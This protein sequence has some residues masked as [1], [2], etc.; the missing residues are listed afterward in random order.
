MSTSIVDALRCCTRGLGARAALGSARGMAVP[1]ALDR[2]LCGDLPCVGWTRPC[3]H[4]MTAQTSRTLTYLAPTFPFIAA[5]S[6]TIANEE[7]IVELYS[8]LRSCRVGIL[9]IDAVEG[10]AVLTSHLLKDIHLSR[11]EAVRIAQAV[12]RVNVTSPTPASMFDETIPEFLTHE[13]VEML[14][15]HNPKEATL[16]TKLSGMTFAERLAVRRAVYLANIA[17]YYYEGQKRDRPSH[18]EALRLAGLLR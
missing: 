11:W 4:I 15:A 1:Y 18:E 7:E 10:C 6:N 16:L 9:A 2:S 5:F 14:Q 17:H 13:H 3:G 12:Q 8:A